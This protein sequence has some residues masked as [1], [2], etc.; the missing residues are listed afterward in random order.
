MPRHLSEAQKVRAIAKL[1]EN[2]S[3]S[4]IA[5]DLNVKSCIFYV[6]KRWQEEQRLQRPVRQGVGKLEKRHYFQDRITARRRLEQSGLKNCAAV[7]KTFVSND[8]KQRRIQF[9]NAFLN[10]GHEFWNNVIFFDEKTFQSYN[11]GRLRVYRPRNTRFEESVEGP[12]DN[13]PV[14][15]SR[16]VRQWADHNNINILPWP[17]KSPDLNPIENV[18][19]FM[20]KQLTKGILGRQIANNF[21]KLSRL[22]GKNLK[23]D[24][25]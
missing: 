3:L 4:E 6:K 10:R 21:G 11:S 5:R 13:S 23:M 24:T 20:V 14:H 9:A 1:E 2:W 7:L 18:R 17:A 12:G 15:A 25:T 16:V 8:H 19:G 22:L